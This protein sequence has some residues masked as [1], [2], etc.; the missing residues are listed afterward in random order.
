[1]A[2]AAGRGR[3]LVVGHFD[4]LGDV[5]IARVT[6]PHLPP[7][8]RVR[9]REKMISWIGSRGTQPEAMKRMLPPS[10]ISKFEGGLATAGQVFL[11]HRQKGVCRT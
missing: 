1:M 5:P 2:R 7:H 11:P 3:D 8:P 4:G 6:A 10:G 9:P